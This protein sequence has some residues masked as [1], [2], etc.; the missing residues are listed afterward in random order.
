MKKIATFGCLAAL[1]I[2]G[3]TAA[4]AC[5]DDGPRA[6][7]SYSYTAPVR[8]Y[9]YAPRTY[10]YTSRTYGYAPANYDYDDDDFAYSY[11]PTLGVSMYGDFGR[12]DRRW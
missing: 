11:G 10:G 12:R 8:A 4:Q 2:A 6:T 1:A 3:G 5:S 7:R 9:S